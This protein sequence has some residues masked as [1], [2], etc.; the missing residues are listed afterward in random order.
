[1][2]KFVLMIIPALICG[3]MFTGC[4]SDKAEMTS[5]LEGTFTGTYSVTYLSSW[6]N[7][8]SGTITI[9]L[10]NGKYICEGIP[11]SQ[12]NISGNYTIDDDKIIFE[13]NVWET[14]YIDKNGYI[15][16]Y[17]FDIYL[18]PQ[19]NIVTHLTEKI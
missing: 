1:M 2:K 9:K 15:I 3:V 5:D 14:N 6:A 17:D 4:S 13:V 19:G 10:K 16:A 8:G 18:V 11:H 7:S 12:A